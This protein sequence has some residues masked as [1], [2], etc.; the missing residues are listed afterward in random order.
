VIK[1]RHGAS[2]APP[3]KFFEHMP[4]PQHGTEYYAEPDKMPIWKNPK[5]YKLAG[6]VLGAACSLLAWFAFIRWQVIDPAAAA[7]VIDWETIDADHATLGR[8]QERALSENGMYV[9]IPAFS[10]D[11]TIFTVTEYLTPSGE[12]GYQTIISTDLV[13]SSKATGPEAED[14]TYEIFIEK[15]VDVTPTST[16]DVLGL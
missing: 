9:H 6:V 5:T 2:E 13:V 1:F 15:P 7:E 10:V 14:R 3:P 4:I 16:G 11:G 8:E 12:R